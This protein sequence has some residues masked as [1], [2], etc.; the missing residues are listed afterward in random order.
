[1]WISFYKSQSHPQGEQDPPKRSLP[2]VSRVSKAHFLAPPGKTTNADRLLEALG[3]RRPSRVGSHRALLRHMDDAGPGPVSSTSHPNRGE[4][5]KMVQHTGKTILHSA[6]ITCSGA[7]AR[8]VIPHPS[9]DS[10]SRHQPRMDP[11]PRATNPRFTGS[12]RTA[13]EVFP[14]DPQRAGIQM[15]TQDV[16]F[17]EVN[18][19]SPWF[20][21]VDPYQSLPWGVSLLCT[22]FLATSKG[23]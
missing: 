19:F 4:N 17:S 16:S 1:M 18:R 10:F 2:K 6:E 22:V 15:E 14:Q 11:L 21:E 3:R 5:Q 7:G 8:C 20:Q 13:P 9:W 12:G 23:A